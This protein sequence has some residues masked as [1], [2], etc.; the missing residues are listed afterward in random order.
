MLAVSTEDK[1]ARSKQTTW[2]V[3]HIVQGMTA[4]IFINL[5][6]YR[7]SPNLLWWESFISWSG[8]GEGV[9]RE[10]HR[11]CSWLS[12]N[13]INV[14]EENKIPPDLYRYNWGQHLTLCHTHFL[15]FKRAACSSPAVTFMILYSNRSGPTTLE[16]IFQTKSAA[17][18]KSKLE[19]E[20]QS[21]DR[22]GGGRLVL[23]VK[24]DR[25]IDNPVTERQLS[26]TKLLEL[27]WK[28]IG[29]L[30]GE[31]KKTIK[32]TWHFREINIIPASRCLGQET[33]C[34][35]Q[36]SRATQP[37]YFCSPPNLEWNHLYTLQCSQQWNYFQLGCCYFC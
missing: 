5:L 22:E 21:R 4:L 35:W 24:G 31:K 16:D 30:K 17:C 36:R 37:W 10:M 20:T 26:S 25:D 3:S 15:T 28:F 33:S 11:Q 19:I 18:K 27:A 1:R 6:L 12:V 32:N 14:V 23:E 29:N 9:Q 34:T 13:R 8:E 7:I 2:L